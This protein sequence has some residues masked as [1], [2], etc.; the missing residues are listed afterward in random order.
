MRKKISPVDARGH[1]ITKGDVVRIVGVPDLSGMAPDSRRE[2]EPLFQY[3]LGKYKRVAGFGRYGHAELPFR[4]GK[5]AALE[6]H[7]VW[8]EPYLLKLKRKRG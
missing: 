8:L 5:G 7:T 2:L 6:L 4:M 1:R 3:L